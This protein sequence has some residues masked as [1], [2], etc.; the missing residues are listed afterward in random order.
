MAAQA[1]LSIAANA[2]AVVGLADVV[3][4]AGKDVIELLFKIHDAPAALS[5]LIDAVRV[6]EGAI[7]ETRSY[8]SD[9]AASDFVSVDH[10]VVPDIVFLL[11]K[12]QHEF[13]H[14]SLLTTATATTP[15]DGWKLLWKKKAVFA[16]N[17]K[18]IER[19][20]RKLE[21]YTQALNTIVLAS[22]G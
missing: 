6:L 9:L 22:E 10:A 12:C 8:I 7:A 5:S 17:E 2:F 1:G 19:A 18:E 13:N 3:F 4:R 16:L 21:R 14:L 20:Q 11:Q 15:Q